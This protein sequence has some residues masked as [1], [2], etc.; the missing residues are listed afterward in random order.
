MP[1]LSFHPA[2]SKRSRSKKRILELISFFLSSPEYWSRAPHLF[3]MSQTRQPRN[4]HLQ[5]TTET[6]RDSSTARLPS[7]LRLR[8]ED[9]SIAPADPSSARRIRWSEDVVDNEGM[10]KKS[11]KGEIRV[12][13]FFTEFT[14]PLTVS[15]SSLLHLP[16]SPTRRR[17]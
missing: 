11:S 1:I 4:A 6:S 14:T 12:L 9:T 8:G 5:T 16:Q 17:E 13:S 15:M 10:G 2:P 3:V 7:T